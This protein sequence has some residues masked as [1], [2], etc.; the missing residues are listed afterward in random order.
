MPLFRSLTFAQQ[1]EV[2]KGGK[3]DFVDNVT[4]LSQSGECGHVYYIRSG[5][6]KETIVSG[7]NDKEM[8][9]YRSIGDVVGSVNILHPQ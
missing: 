8:T 2:K 6:V 1:A 5:T 4:I 3:V 9:F 7:E